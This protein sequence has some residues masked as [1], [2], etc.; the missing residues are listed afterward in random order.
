M[1]KV[2]YTRQ[3]YREEYLKSSEWKNLRSLV[4]DA[5]CECQ[6]CKLTTA[7]DVHHLVYRNLV[8]ITIKD[9]LPVCRKCHD[10]IHDAI[11]CEY[12]SQNPNDI[13]TI[14][15]KTLNIINDEEFLNWK[16]WYTTKHFLSEEEI[17]LIT[18]LQPFIIKRISGLLKKNIWYEDL[19]NVK[20]TGKQLL[21]IEAMIE[22]AIKRKKDKLDK[23]G[24]RRAYRMSERK[25]IKYIKK[26]LIS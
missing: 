16:V 26:G 3:E 13:E 12:I 20:F 18:K 5:G 1:H 19:P 4:L 21:K 22:L 2:K 24:D 15:H 7:N 8:D 14:V 10:I 25:I 6:C 17:A 9:L 23:P 11:N